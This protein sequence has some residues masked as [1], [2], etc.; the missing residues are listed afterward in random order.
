MLCLILLL[1]IGQLIALAAERLLAWTFGG[2]FEFIYAGVAV[3][4]IAGAT[5]LTLPSKQEREQARKR[6]RR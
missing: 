3:F 2:S 1:G 4:A 6:R 5:W